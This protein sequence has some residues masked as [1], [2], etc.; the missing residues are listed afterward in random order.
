M[1]KSLVENQAAQASH[2]VALRLQSHQLIAAAESLA[3]TVQQLK[4]LVLLS[5]TEGRDQVLKEEKEELDKQKAEERKGVEE[6]LKNLDGKGKQK[7]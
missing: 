5:D 1:Q 2:A 7:E 6:G 3:T 4:L